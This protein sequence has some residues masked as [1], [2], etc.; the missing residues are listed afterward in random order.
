MEGGSW[1]RRWSEHGVGNGSAC[2]GSVSAGKEN[3]VIVLRWNG[4]A[5][6]ASDDESVVSVDSAADEDDSSSYTSI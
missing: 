2:S 1:N 4:C 5:G 6:G 3:V